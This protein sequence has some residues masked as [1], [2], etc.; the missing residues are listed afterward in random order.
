MI[1]VLLCQPFNQ[2]VHV[3]CLSLTFAALPPPHPQG[4]GAFPSNPSFPIP[5]LLAVKWVCRQQGYVRE[6]KVP[7]DS[8]LR[9]CRHTST[10]SLLG[11][12]GHS[13]ALP[14]PQ[15]P[16]LLNGRVGS[17]DPEA[18]LGLAA[19]LGDSHCMPRWL[20][21]LPF[22]LGSSEDSQAV[23]LHPPSTCLF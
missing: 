17:G 15:F 5:N 12:L 7:P 10:L 1:P 14:G 21:D 19:S 11:D 4:W 13:L 9:G 6:E 20:A 16:C 23:S 2:S 8:G 18:F 22:I 3:P